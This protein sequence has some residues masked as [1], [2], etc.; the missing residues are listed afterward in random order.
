MSALGTAPLLVSARD[1]RATWRQRWADASATTRTRVQVG[2]FLGVVAV[3]YHYSLETLI[4]TLNLNTPL[5]YIGLVPLIALCMAAVRSRPATVEP[6]IHDRQVDY[7]VGVPLVVAALAINFLLPRQ[8]SAMFWVWRIDLLSL[9][10]FVAGVA[11]I[12][13]GVRAVWRQRLAL[14]YLFLAWPLPYSLVL[15]GL[16]G[17]FTNITL[18]TLAPLSTKLHV[19]SPVPGGDGSIFQVTHAGR[20]FPMSVVSACSGV[21]GMVGFLLVGAAFGAIVTGP[22]IRKALWLAFGLLLLWAINL[23]RLLF[24]FWSGKHYGEHF[25]VQVLHPFIGLVTFNIGVVIMILL[26]KPAGLRLGLR[27]PNGDEGDRAASAGPS[28][29]SRPLAVPRVY[30]AIA[31]VVVAGAILGVNNGGLRVYD[32][33]ANAAGE[34]KLASYLSYPASPPGWEKAVFA[35]EFTFAR[36]FFGESSRWFRWSYLADPAGGGDLSASIPVVADVV[37]T[38]DLSSFSAYGVEAC[39]RF[40]GYSL[41]DV[42]E[43]N[44]GGGITGQALSYSTQRNSDWTLVYWIWPI[45]NSPKTRYE[46]VILYMQDTA[47]AAVQSPGDVGGIKSLRGALTGRDAT[48]R[49]LIRNRTFLVAFAREVIKAQAAIPVGAILPHSRDATDR[50]A[51][52]GQSSTAVRPGQ[53]PYRPETTPTIVPASS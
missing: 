17:R 29:A 33:V 38:S 4:K 41:R 49:V 50:N 21:N 5:A 37:N 44:L 26:L 45:K 20:A 43:V 24:I 3:A 42:A 28:A 27:A 7:I 25:A 6:A 30:A 47:A 18:K 11:S 13:F 1:F 36:P 32:L 31:L 35:Y 15:L 51:P 10:F 46:R 16:L 14:A 48:E 40:H 8:L 53:V 19:A 23:A 2:V 39:Y 52:A 12:I 34:P 9:P 22:R